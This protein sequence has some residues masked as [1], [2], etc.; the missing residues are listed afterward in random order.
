ME[1]EGRTPD[2]A[3]LVPMTPTIRAIHHIVLARLSGDPYQGVEVNRNADGRS[4]AEMVRHLNRDAARG[5]YALHILRLGPT[6]GSSI[7]ERR[8]IACDIDND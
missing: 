7:R 8:P 1:V 6:A 2:T 5:I 3:F 4:K